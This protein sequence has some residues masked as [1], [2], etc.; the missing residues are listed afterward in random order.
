M[1]Q[2]VVD[3][4]DKMKKIHAPLFAEAKNILEVGSLDINGSPRPYFPPEAKYV[5]LDWREGPGVDVVSLAHKYKGHPDASF[6]F[7]ISTE[8]LEHDPHWKESVKRMIALLAPAGNLLITCAGPERA[9]HEAGCSP[10]KNYYKNITMP[11]LVTVI[12]SQATFKGASIED[13]AK[14][15]DLRFFGWRKR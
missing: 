5:G 12:F 9:V 8:M 4:L 15:H 6:D 2:E 14:A 11:E 13:D 1:H 10:K 7:V 3:F